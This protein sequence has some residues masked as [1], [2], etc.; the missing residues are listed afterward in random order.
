[1]PESFLIVLTLIIM[2]IGVAGVILPLLPDIWLI[3]LAALGYGL[4]AGFDGWVGG[5]AMT[6]ITLLMMVGIIADVAMSHAGAASG[7]AS[8]QGILASFILGTVG[9]FIFP[10]IGPLVGAVVG[11]F[12]VEY[13]RQKKDVRKAWRA[14]TGYAAGCGLSMIA[15]LG[16]AILMILIWGAWVWIKNL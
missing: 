13:F 4:L 14:I 15:R 6:L 11:L 8:W 7:G 16:I 2:L 5:I 1:M 10:P 9:L 12:L 3:W